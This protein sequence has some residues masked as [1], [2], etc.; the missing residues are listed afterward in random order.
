MSH[1][2]HGC[3]LNCTLI[4]AEWLRKQPLASLRLPLAGQP[5]RNG[6]CIPATATVT[7][8][9]PLPRALPSTYFS[10][11]P[12]CRFQSRKYRK[13]VI[14]RHANGALWRKGSTCLKHS[15]PRSTP[16]RQGP[17]QCQ[18]PRHQRLPLQRQHLCLRSPRLPLHSPH[19]PLHGMQLPPHSQHL[20]LQRL[21]L[22][23]WGP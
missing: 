3:P 23:L 13:T 14:N 9:Q 22:T 17:C 21:P 20:P 7:A 8:V 4:C 16:P 6:M 15:L 18:P 1:S 12:A 10:Y 19:P 5:H 11:W 2:E